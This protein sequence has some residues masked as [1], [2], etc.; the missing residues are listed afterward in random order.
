MRG[1]KNASESDTFGAP[2]PP[3]GAILI[4]RVSGKMLISQPASVSPQ[5][6]A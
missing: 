5:Q 1:S 4:L 6:Q 3:S 2:L